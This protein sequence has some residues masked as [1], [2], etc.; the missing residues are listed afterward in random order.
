MALSALVATG[1][2]TL[3]VIALTVIRARRAFG[4]VASALVALSLLNS[5]IARGVL[6]VVLAVAVFL[7]ARARIF[8]LLI[9]AAFLA[10]IRAALFLATLIFA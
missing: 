10:A 8:T 3:A 6:R 1:L 5:S 7:I 2:V 9:L 4:L